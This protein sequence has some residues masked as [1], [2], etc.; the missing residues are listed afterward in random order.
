ME[1]SGATTAN[2]VAKSANLLVDGYGGPTRVGLLLPLHW[3][4][5]ALLLAGVATGATVV[6]TDEP[7]ELAGTEVAFVSAEHAEAALSAG[8]DEVLALSGHPL[9][10]RLTTVPS[11]VVDDAVE[12]PA[13]GDSWGGPV[14][15]RL[16]VEAGG[17]VLPALPE[18]GLG[19]ADR[20]LTA[21]RPADPEGLAAL[22][23]VL[24]CGAALVLVPDPGAVDLP[25]VAEQEGVTATLGVAVDGLAALRVGT[26]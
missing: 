22:L 5:V 1:L 25:R 15:T 4:T 12:V 6:V 18:V 24:R 8:A 20:V 26:G 11:G 7:A 9:G 19:R 3:Q 23:A 17:A 21:V 16:D 13:Y 10:A 14:P 2:W